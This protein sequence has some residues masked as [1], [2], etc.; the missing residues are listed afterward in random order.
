MD[1]VVLVTGAGSGI[2][3]ACA[4]AFAREGAA[5]VIADVSER[6]AAETLDRVRAEG[7]E[8]R[9]IPCDISRADQVEALLSE[10]VEAYG[11]LDCAVNNAGIQG[12]IAS[13]VEC[14]VEN[15]QRTIATNLTGTWLC[16]KAEIAQ[17]IR[18]GHGSV[19]NVSSNFG[20]V[21]SAGMPAY[22]ASKHGIIGLTRT[23]A[24]MIARPFD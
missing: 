24:M 8:G 4:L 13:T 9:V 3:R 11:R 22:S 15:W 5:V 10:V 12:D 17:M 20:Q 23:A 19:V 1:E 21:G 7:A 2:G 14:S 6:G 18:Q 16:M